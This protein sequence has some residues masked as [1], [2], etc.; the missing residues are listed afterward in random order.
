MSNSVRSIAVDSYVL[1]VLMHDL[2]GHTVVD[3]M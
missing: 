1:D 2:V 3:R